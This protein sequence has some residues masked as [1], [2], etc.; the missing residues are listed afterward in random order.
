MGDFYT[1]SGYP[2]TGSAGLSASARAEFQLIQAG[3]DKLPSLSGNANK[4]VVVNAGATGL[5]VTSAQLVLSGSF[6]K[7][8]SDPL[9]LSTT[10]P[11]TLTLPTTGTLATLAGSE[12]LTNKTLTAPIISGSWAITTTATNGHG[13][14]AAPDATAGL[15][16][17]LAK[18]GL[19]GGNARGFFSTATVTGGIS[20]S[21]LCHH[22]VSSAVKAA[23]GTHSAVDGLILSAL[24][25]SGSATAT[26]ASTFRILG[27]PSSGATNLY[28]M[29]I[30]SGTTLMGGLLDLSGASAGQIKFP[31]SANAS[32]DVNTLDD[33]E[34]GTFTPTLGGSATY[35][36]RVGSYTKIGNR[37][38]VHILL[39]VGTLGTGSTSTIS[40]LPFTSNANGS[41]LAIGQFGNLAGP[42]GWIGARVNGNATTVTIYSS[43]AGGSN[44]A[45]VNAVFADNASIVLSGHYYV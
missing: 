27:P 7:G 44:N 42:V 31:A 26:N 37:V 35:S 41:S 20:D 39:T 14:G 8:G 9:T 18:T 40:G 38:Y 24:S 32:A 34:E 13:I 36:T 15:T 12:T 6:T 19:G 5:S 17:N 1:A 16:I 3:F 2:S 30:D 29:R 22:L 10:A 4:V 23:S 43:V 11:T 45:S 28:A 33:Y 25:I 21:I